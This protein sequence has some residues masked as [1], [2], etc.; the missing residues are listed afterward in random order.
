MSLSD[1]AATVVAA[2]IIGIATSPAWFRIRRN[3]HPAPPISPD[4]ARIEAELNDRVRALDERLSARYEG[5]ITY[6]RATI[7]DRERDLKALRR[8]GNAND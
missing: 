5:E 2:L 4:P 6:L 7:E 1:P 8:K 3:R